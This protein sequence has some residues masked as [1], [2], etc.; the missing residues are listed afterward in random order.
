MTIYGTNKPL[1]STGPEEL[2]DN[3]QNLDFAINDITK[4]I[5]KDR[6]GRN[7]KTLWGAEQEFSAQLLN[8]QQR[9]NYFIQNS[10]Y[11]FLGEYTSGPLTVREY[12]QLIRYENEFWKLNA[13]TT[14]PFTTTGNN[15]ASWVN[16]SAHFVSAGDDALRQ[17]LA[18]TGG[19]GLVGTERGG[20]L[21][22]V[23]QDINSGFFAEFGPQLRKLNSALLDPLVQE[24]QITFIGDS[25][26]WGTG[27][28]GAAG[29]GTRDGTLSDPR[30]NATSPSY[31]NQLGRH[32][33]DI[34]GTGTVTTLSNHS[35]SPSGESIREMVADKYEFPY[36][37]AYSVVGSGSFTDVIDANVTG[38]YLGAR[39]TITVTTGASASLSFN[40]TGSK[41]SLVYSQLTNSADYELLVNGVSQGVFTTRGATAAFNTRRSHSFGY[42]INGTVT[43]RAVQ[44]SGDTGNQQLRLEALLLP[45]T[46][47]IKNQGIIGTTTERYATYN[48]PTTLSRPKPYPPQNM[49]GFSQTFVGTGGHEYV[50]SAEPN[51]ILGMRYKYSFTNTGSW[52]ITLK[53]AATDDRVAIYFSSTD[54]T[55]DV[56]VLADGVAIETF[57]TSSNEQGVP[58]GYQNSRIVS[59]PAG[60]TTVKIK[61]VFVQYQSS[62]SYLYLEGLTTFNSSSQTYPTN[63]SFNDGVALDDKDMFAFFQVGVNDRASNQVKS[64]TQ[65]R[66]QLEKMLSLVPQG[67]SPILMASN[68]AAEA[69][70]YSMQDMVQ[71]IRQTAEKYNVAFIDNFNLFDKY[72]MAY[73]TTDNLHPNDIGHNM[74]ARNIIKSIRSS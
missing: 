62:V 54:K 58:F 31:V 9:F 52:E 36:G 43:I 40:F 50:E 72:S 37:S 35:Y 29:S 38:P 28:T 53:P 61:T 32:I 73:F 63:N 20:N 69:G 19:A 3:S 57:H 26:T 42:V 47:R 7:R 2:F 4:A 55:C 23:L 66:T 70:N 18:S 46:V 27:S 15:A 33:A 22:L 5:W 68:P 51:A 17:G 64:P 34:L 48:F 74:I 49:P 11:K 30:N 71:A 60:T 44:H 10:G 56:Q 67:C 24:L 8:Q 21:D 41:F 13:A 25:I 16:D 6:F 39:R 59:I 14:P 1:G 12:N 45:K 65:I